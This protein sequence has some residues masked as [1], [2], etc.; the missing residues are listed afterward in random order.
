M[1]E[2][3]SERVDRLIVPTTCLLVNSSTCQLVYLSTRLLVNLSTCITLQSWRL[4]FSFANDVFV[5]RVY[6]GKMKVRHVEIKKRK[7]FTHL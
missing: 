3:T 7:Y 1:N 6:V 2:L 4:I 5:L